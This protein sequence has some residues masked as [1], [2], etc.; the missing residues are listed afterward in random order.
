MQSPD[1]S[2]SPSGSES[3]VDVCKGFLAQEEEKMRKLENEVAQYERDLQPALERVREIEAHITAR[4]DQIKSM[5]ILTNSVKRG[6]ELNDDE[7]P[8]K[9]RRVI[10]WGRKSVLQFASSTST[11]ASIPVSVIVGNSIVVIVKAPIVAKR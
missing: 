7:L 8:R 2:S 4:K 3:G 9:R 6:I 11:P 1:S 5:Q 10:D